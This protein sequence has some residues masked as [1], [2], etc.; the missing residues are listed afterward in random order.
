MP[1]AQSKPKTALVLSAGGMFGA[2]QAGAWRAICD[3]FKP[4]MVV[5]AS[6]GALNGWSIAGG[7]SAAEVVE[8]WL[9]PATGQVLRLKADAGL[10]RGWFDPAPLRQHARELHSLYTPRIPFGLVVV[11][12]GRFRN[13]LVQHPDVTVEHLTA[14]ASIPVCLPSVAIDGRQY[15][16]GG[17]FDKLPVWAAVEMG[18]TR[19]V[20]IDCLRISNRWIRTGIGAIR[21]LKWRRKL[22][23]DLEITLVAPEEALGTWKDAVFW[24]RENVERWIEMGER[25]ASRALAPH[26]IFRR[27]S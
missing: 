22:P 13:R 9:D 20:A 21:M 3:Q 18:A 1:S 25:D 12:A 5:G 8:R 26:T 15:L 16:D 14:T 2:Y 4:D 27:A 19:I 11:E 24:K 7:C 6:V 10:R 23:E 17:L